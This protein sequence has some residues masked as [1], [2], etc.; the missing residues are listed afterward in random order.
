MIYRLGLATLIPSLT[1]WC[2]STFT[3]KG[4]AH[5]E[6]FDVQLA[7]SLSVGLLIQ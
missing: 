6:L 5:T 2:N 7:N 4:V 1:A 3:K